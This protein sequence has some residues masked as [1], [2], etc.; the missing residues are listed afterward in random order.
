MKTYNFRRQ[1]QIDASM[2]EQ[3]EQLQV[4]R[5]VRHLKRIL[6]LLLPLS[7]L[8]TFLSLSYSYLLA[9]GPVIIQSYAD[10]VLATFLI[11]SFYGLMLVL[12]AYYSRLHKL[13]ATKQVILLAIIFII[14]P[15]LSYVYILGLWLLNRPHEIREEKSS[16]DPGS[17]SVVTNRSES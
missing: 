9:S 16:Q 12:F 13:L 10:P 6:I 5:R 3:E 4:A 15:I 2:D 14:Y 1:A 17:G 8:G 7:V 11:W